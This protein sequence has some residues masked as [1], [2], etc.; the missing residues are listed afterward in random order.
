MLGSNQSV[1]EWLEPSPCPDFYTAAMPEPKLYSFCTH[2]GAACARKMVTFADL[3]EKLKVDVHQLMKE[4]NG[5][6]NRSAPRLA[7]RG[8]AY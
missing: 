6:W 8:D 5:R 1:G 2:I 4:C 3:A 7:D